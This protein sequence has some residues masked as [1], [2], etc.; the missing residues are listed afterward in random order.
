MARAGNNQ[1]SSDGGY[2]LKL[3][4]QKLRKEGLA[5]LAFRS[6][7]YPV[8]FAL[9]DSKVEGMPGKDRPMERLQICKAV[10]RAA[11]EGLPSKG[12]QKAASILFHMDSSGTAPSLDDRRRMADVAFCGRQ[13]ARQPDT[14]QRSLEHQLLDPPLIE[15]LQRLPPVGNFGIST[16]T[17]RTGSA[18]ACTTQPDCN[19]EKPSGLIGLGPGSHNIIAG[20]E[21][22]LAAVLR[23]LAHA[24]GIP[25]MGALQIHQA[26]LVLA[27]E[28]REGQEE[29]DVRRRRFMEVTGGAAAG[30]ILVPAPFVLG[31]D[32]D[33]L[34]EYCDQLATGAGL[35]PEWADPVLYSSPEV[36]PSRV[37]S[38]HVSDIESTTAAL[39]ALDYRRGG[40]A[41]LEALVG[42]LR[43]SQRLLKAPSDDQVRGQLVCALADLNNQA[44]WESHDS[45][46]HG[47]ALV[48][49][50]RALEQARYLGEHSLAANV[51]CQM[52]WVYLHNRQPD[53]ALKYVELGQLAAQKSK[54]ELTAAL[55]LVSEAWVQAVLGDENRMRRSIQRAQD[56]YARGDLN[57][58]PPWLKFFIETDFR[59]L[60]GEAN[61]SLMKPSAQAYKDA[62]AHLYHAVGARNP[63]MIRERTLDLIPLARA[64]LI[65]RDTD[66]AVRFGMEAVTL[67][68]HLQS[69]RVVE[70]LTPL[71]EAALTHGGGG[72]VAELAE[73]I[74]LLQAA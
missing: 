13:S 28:F 69:V 64:H 53:V 30:V 3:E 7:R 1:R 71:R 65:N 2:R 22:S 6:E 17:V 29:D 24:Q 47:T 23:L 57:H 26:Q 31:Q 36:V 67:T 4:L 56:A 73:R 18:V 41:C 52:G 33:R 32:D 35:N 48:F 14:I 37:T 44:G 60:I 49:F 10:F 21:R 9:V 15:I 38:G 54:C 5:D 59:A 46:A 74:A 39:R 8:L 19:T 34:L 50:R 45:G 68:E 25:S 55:L 61:A 66:V 58:A 11:I 40:G 16:K 42:H 51:L 63:E 20:D 43:S 72:E 70:Q 12:L 27:T 62:T